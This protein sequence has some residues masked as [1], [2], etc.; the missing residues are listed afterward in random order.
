[1]MGGGFGAGFLVRFGAPHILI[2]HIRA[3]WKSIAHASGRAGQQPRP[4][5]RSLGS[6]NGAY[7]PQ[8]SQQSACRHASFLPTPNSHTHVSSLRIRSDTYAPPS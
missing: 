1:M 3:G 2:C 8:H 5:S 7:P 6:V 4:H